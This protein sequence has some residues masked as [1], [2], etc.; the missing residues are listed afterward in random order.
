MSQILAVQIVWAPYFLAVGAFVGPTANKTESASMRTISVIGVFFFWV[1][2]FD[3]SRCAFFPIV[4]AI[5]LELLFLAKG[6][7]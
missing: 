5:L 4:Y 6:G 1:P 7:D 2:R 3:L